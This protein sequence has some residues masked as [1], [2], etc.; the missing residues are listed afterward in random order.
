MEL[1]AKLWAFYLKRVSFTPTML[2]IWI[3]TAVFS[4]SVEDMYVYHTVWPENLTGNLI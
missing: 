2:N 3:V 4:Q 1:L